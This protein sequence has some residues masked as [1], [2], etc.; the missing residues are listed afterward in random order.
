[1]AMTD[2]FN[3]AANDNF[4]GFYV[5]VWRQSNG[6][7]FYVGKGSGSRAYTTKSRS[8]EFKE[9]YALGGCTVEIVDWFIHESQ[10]HALEVD[11]IARYGRR[12]NGGLLVNKTDGG[13]GAA[14]CVRGDET[15]A[16]ISK[17][18]RGRTFDDGWRA[19]IGAAHRGRSLSDEH[20]AKLSEA[21]RGRILTADERTKVSHAKR[22]M[23]PE[24]GFKGV[25]TA[26]VG[27]WRARIKV[28]GRLHYLGYFAAPEQAARAYDVA[29]DR[30]WGA[31]PWYRNFA[32]AGVD[33]ASV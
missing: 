31:G 20:R 9:I 17:A 8:G 12:E 21:G 15:R 28:D 24:A 22:V 16:R 30:F 13:E 1:M 11:L 27:K 5:Y 33:A 2:A 10:A 3:G 18:L 7:P 25:T 23:A 29:V 26:G 14:G 19:K 4:P 32:G 6:E